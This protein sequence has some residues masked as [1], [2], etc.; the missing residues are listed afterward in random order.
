M[1]LREGLNPIEYNAKFA[2]VKKEKKPV[3]I[4]KTKHGYAVQL[5]GT[6][7]QL[8]E[9]TGFDISFPVQ[10]CLF[11]KLPYTV[12]IPSPTGPGYGTKENHK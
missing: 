3:E 1:N 2:Q 9:F 7:T 11:H 12:N 6:D 4:V 10:F 8:E 5:V